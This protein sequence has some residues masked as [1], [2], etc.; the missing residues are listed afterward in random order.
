MCMLSRGQR[1]FNAGKIFIASAWYSWTQ[2]NHCCWGSSVYMVEL[3]GLFNTVSEK[4]TQFVFVSDLQVTL[5]SL[6]CACFAL[7]YCIGKFN[8]NVTYLF[9]CVSFVS[10]DNDQM[11]NINY[12]I[13]CRD[14]YCSAYLC[15]CLLLM[16]AVCDIIMC[17]FSFP[18]ICRSAFE[19]TREK[20]AFLLNPILVT[21]LLWRSEIEDT[22]KLNCVRLRLQS[23][24]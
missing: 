1:H 2:I 19:M 14:Y 13:M 21:S 18:H 17:Y 20:I 23:A 6:C 24:N 16:F 15:Y 10:F 8:N 9:A 22:R 11:F 7:Q 12:L 3:V 5:S 4:K